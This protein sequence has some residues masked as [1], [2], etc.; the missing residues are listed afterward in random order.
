M[1]FDSRHATGVALGGLI[2]LAAGMGIGRFVYTP[3]LPFMEEALGLTKPQAGVIASV[4]FLGYLLGALA[5]ALSTLPGGRRAWLFGALGVSAVTTGAMG[6]TTSMTI[7]F[8]LRFVG[9]AASAFVLVF[10]SALVLDRLA[11]LGRSGLSAIH[12]A[13]VGVGIAVSA[14]LVSG[15]SASGVG[16]QAQW[17]ASGA[18]ALLALAVV[19]WLVPPVGEE[20]DRSAAPAHGASIDRRLIGLIVAYGLFGFGYVITATFISTMVRTAPQLQPIEP[21]VWLVVGLAGIPSIAFWTWTGRLWG[22]DRSF[23]LAC[24]VEAFGV[25]LSVLTTNAAVVLLGAAL[26]GGTFMGITALGFIYARDLTPG[27][28]RRSLALMTASFGLGQ[29]IG[30]TFAGVTFRFG[31]SFLFPSLVATGA[32]L[33]A[34]YLAMDVRTW[35][36]ASTGRT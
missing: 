14:I 11:A 9:G 17:L 16:W 35:S 23:A 10:A 30:P 24:L 13:G 15:L 32:L 29:M 27:D 3:V 20:D 36:R 6:L 8:G 31:D 7:F 19:M 1:T 28:P 18:V 12:F 22:N 25:A 33:I 5:A 2:A 4:N 21:V 34:A 26:L